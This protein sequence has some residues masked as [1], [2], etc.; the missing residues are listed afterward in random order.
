MQ[1]TKNFHLNEFLKSQTAERLGI[2]NLPTAAEIA[3]IR[4]VAENILQ[5]IRDNYAVAVRISSGFRCIE[6]NR[7]IGSHDKSQHITGSAVDFEVDGV[8]NLQVARFVEKKL[9]FDQLI[10]E[11]HDPAIPDSG[12]VHV[13]YINPIKNRK[14]VL[15]INKSGTIQGLPE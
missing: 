4:A 15:T 12:W 10:L 8:P 6:L 3:N 13:S 2:Q 5:P 7:A 14:Q 11:F 9:D 1:L